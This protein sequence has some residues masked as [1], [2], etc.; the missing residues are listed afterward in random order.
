[1]LTSG[2]TSGP[3]DACCTNCSQASALFLARPLPDTIAAVLE[4]EPEWQALPAKTPAK[5]RELLRKCLQKDDAPAG[6]TSRM[7]DERS[8]KRNVDGTVGESLRL[9]RPRW[10][11]C[12]WW[13]CGAR[14][15]SASDRSQWVQLTKLPD[16]VSQPALSADG[17][18][19]AF[20]RSS[21][22]YYALGQVYVKELPDGEPVQLTH[23]SLKK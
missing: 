14:P 7:L 9:R 11:C 8:K 20:V 12:H 22:T 13:V 16:P 2:Q 17:R 4:R 10:Q 23:D 5:I 6:T 21:S 19:L 1:M 3:S 18:M 15:G